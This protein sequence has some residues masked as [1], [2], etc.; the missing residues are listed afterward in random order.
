MEL[1]GSELSLA[2]SGETRGAG[3]RADSR[4]RSQQ[5]PLET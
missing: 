2:R 5:Q 1:D 4:I 3:H